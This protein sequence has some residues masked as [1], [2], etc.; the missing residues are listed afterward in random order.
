M[1]QIL[2]RNLDEVVVDRLKQRAREEGHSLQ[3][4]VRTILS[5]AAFVPRPKKE[6]TRKR[7]DP[8][9]LLEFLRNANI[10]GPRDWATNLD[11]Y[12]TGE[13]DLEAEL[14]KEEAEER[15]TVVR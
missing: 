11:A 13:K 3:A 2:V 6:T 9:P 15:G 7:K 8:R 10:K 1:A 4:E 14:A 12:L 5:E